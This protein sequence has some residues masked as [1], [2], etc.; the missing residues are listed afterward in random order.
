MSVWDKDAP[1]SWFVI[2]QGTSRTRTYDE[3]PTIGQLK[4]HAFLSPSGRVRVETWEGGT[5]TSAFMYTRSE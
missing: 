1:R 5:V 2:V 4:F 3:A